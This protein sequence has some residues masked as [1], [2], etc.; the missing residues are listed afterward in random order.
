[1]NPR[2]SY[3][4]QGGVEMMQICTHGIGN[5]NIY[6]SNWASFSGSRPFVLMKYSEF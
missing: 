3:R 5:S 6:N 1:M 4:G 2:G